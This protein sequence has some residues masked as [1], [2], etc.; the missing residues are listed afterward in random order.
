[1]SDDRPMNRRSFFRRGLGELLKP[2][3]NAIAPVE[4][5]LRELEKL[6]RASPAP[7]NTVSLDLWLRPPGALPEAQLQSTCSKC[8]KCV[9]VCPAAAIKLDPT[10]RLGNGVPYIEPDTLACIVCEGLQCMNHCPTGALV[11]TPLIDIDMGTAVWRS[12]SCVR[13]TEGR[14]CTICVDQCPLG[15]AAIKLEGNEIAVN[16]HGCV[17]CG[18]CQQYCPTAPRSIVVIPIA[19]RRQ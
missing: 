9:D 19:A 1:M 12:E 11:P 3:A 7:K 4:S 14:D 17:G 18:L 6:D 2:L 13:E 16:P 10:G 5:T 15:Q 8:A